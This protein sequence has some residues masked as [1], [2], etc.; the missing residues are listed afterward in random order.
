MPVTLGPGGTRGF[1]LPKAIRPLAKAGMTLAHVAYRLLGDRMRVQGQR[2]LEL[3]TLGGTSGLER[4]VTLARFDDPSHPGSWLVIG[5]NNG[6]ARHPGWCYNLVKNPDHV[7]VTIGKEQ[8]KVR[9]DSLEGEERDAAWRRVVSLSPGYG[10]Y[11]RTTDRQI[12]VIRLTPVGWP[13]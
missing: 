4:H 12:P 6:A 3:N 9:A 11:E 10:R 2:L 13:S 7:T 1:E 8:V 5:S